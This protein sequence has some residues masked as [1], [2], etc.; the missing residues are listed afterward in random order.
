MTLII[1]QLYKLSNFVK[2]INNTVVNLDEKH[3]HISKD[4]TNLTSRVKMNRNT[5][6]T[7]QIIQTGI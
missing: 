1:M 5:S 2:I 6:K 3:T 7:L 4:H